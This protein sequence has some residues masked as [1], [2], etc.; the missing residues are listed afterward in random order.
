VGMSTVPEVITAN[1]SGIKCVAVSVLTDECDPDNLKPVSLAEIIAVASQTD[2]I[3]T[4][5]I[6][7]FVGRL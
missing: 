1:H 4:K 3:L 7:E 6:V 5:L 2:A